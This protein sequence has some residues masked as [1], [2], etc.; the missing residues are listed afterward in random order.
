M[1]WAKAVTQGHRFG[2]RLHRNPD[3]TP[4]NAAATTGHQVNPVWTVA[5]VPTNSTMPKARTI[6]QK[7]RV[8]MAFSSVPDA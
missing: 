6:H 5:M 4:I 3:A 1:D 8:L 7:L 2:C